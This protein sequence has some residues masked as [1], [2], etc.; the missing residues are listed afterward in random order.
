MRRLFLIVAICF[1]SLG[2]VF[3]QGFSSPPCVI[4][5]NDT[6]YYTPFYDS[7]PCIERGLPYSSSMQ[8]GMPAIF[9]SSILLD[10][11]V[12][13]SITGLPA[14]I[15]YVQNPPSGVYYGGAGGCIAFAGTTS[16]DSGAYPLAFTGYAVISTQSS[17]TQTYSLSQ[18]AQI[19][20]APVPSYQLH[21]IYPG[22]SCF[23]EPLG[24]YYT[25]GVANL[26]SPSQLSIYPNPSGGT[27]N[28]EL[29]SDKDINGELAVTDVTGKIV[30]HQAL[31]TSGFYKSVINLNNCARGFYLLQL[32][33]SEGLISKSISLQ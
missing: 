25:L 30:Y 8:V 15:S 13:T 6:G 22:D 23:S 3:S 21:I 16:N 20:D 5:V 29:N 4:T 12:I 18:L 2:F 33:T 31:N 9:N 27:F 14:G 24:F 10:S 11:L 26:L 32:R 17:G 1:A 19:Q 28:L 7:L